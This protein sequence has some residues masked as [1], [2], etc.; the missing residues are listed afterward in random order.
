MSSIEEVRNA[1]IRGDLSALAAIHAQGVDV[2]GAADPEEL[3]TLHLACASGNLD[4]VAWL[5]RVCHA[6]PHCAR[7]NNFFPIHAAAMQ[8]HAEVVRHLLTAGAAPNVQ[9]NPQGYAPLHSS[10]WAGHVETVHVLVAAGADRT[11]RNYRGETP[12]ETARRQNHHALAAQLDE[13]TKGLCLGPRVSEFSWGSVGLDTGEVFK[14]A[15]LW[16]GGARAW[17]W[18]ETGTRHVPGI[19][20]A[21]VEE[22][23]E[24][25]CEVL[26]LS[27]GQQLVLETQPDV[28]AALRATGVEVLYLE[29]KDAV[30]MYNELV[31]A[32]RRVGA[33]IHS[34]C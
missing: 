7:Q 11:L 14:D 24:H 12:A 29:S 1:A 19:Q 8:G 22:L 28:I 26:I 16:P 15:K 21:D 33:L 32:G 34:T 3:T 30:K 2:L 13:A 27:R 17:D 23:L 9:T 5:V 31:A 25:D 20:M 18:R 10:A 4:L 6:D